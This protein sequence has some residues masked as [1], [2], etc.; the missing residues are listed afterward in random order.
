LPDC[1]FFK[2]REQYP[3]GQSLDGSLAGAILAGLCQ[4]RIEPRRVGWHNRGTNQ[5]RERVQG[6]TQA[7]GRLRKPYF[8]APRRARTSLG[9]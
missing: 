9:E 2:H 4:Q 5:R 7:G 1:S 8:G 6:F 3:P